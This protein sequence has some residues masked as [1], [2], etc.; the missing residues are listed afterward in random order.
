MRRRTSRRSILDLV[1]DDARRL[2]RRLG[3][4][5]RLKLDE[6][7]AAVRQLERR[8]ERAE[9]ANA[10]GDRPPEDMPRDHREHVRLLLDV[11]VLAFRADL[12]RVLT[13][14]FANEGSNRSYPFV[15]AK[16]GHHQLSHH[17]GDEKKIRAIRA[18]N[19]F[20]TSQLS[21]YLQA[22]REAPEGEGTLLD[23]SMVVYGSGIREGNRHD[24][25]DL[26]IVLA[27]RGGGT[28][29]PGR[30]VRYPKETPLCNLYLSLLDRFGVE[31]A[32]FG[33]S[34]GRLPHLT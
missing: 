24:H 30:H 28:I 32:R 17:G 13:F 10:K 12:T 6:Y 33:D 15:G 14:M 19:R 27:G 22:L 20:H 29:S 2:E 16:G 21:Y 23:R 31:E 26:P 1:R 4:A 7:L 25:H 34:T 18:I 3:G 11:A 8:I 5:D 9:Q